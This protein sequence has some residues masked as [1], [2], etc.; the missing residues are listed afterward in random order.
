M[1]VRTSF[2][3]LGLFLTA[4][5]IGLVFGSCTKT[6]IKEP[7]ISYGII[8]VNP[9]VAATGDTVNIFGAGFSSDTSGNIVTI[10]GGGARVVSASAQQLRVIVPSGVSRGSVGVKTG[11]QSSTFTEQ[12][13]L[14]TVISGN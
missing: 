10:N 4:I 9:E 7:G 8:G 2:H 14:E 11:S 5:A 6:T 1:L 12:F 3:C 13:T